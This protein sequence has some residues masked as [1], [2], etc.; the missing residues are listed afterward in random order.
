[1][2]TS[3]KKP[4]PVLIQAL[5]TSVYG[6]TPTQVGAELLLHADGSIS[7]NLG[8][9]HLEHAVRLAILE[10]RISLPWGSKR[11][12]L[13]GENDQCCGGVVEVSL[14]HIPRSLAPLY[15]SQGDRYYIR[16]GDFLHLLGGYTG[17]GV[18]FG[19]TY[20][21]KYQ[22]LVP[23]W[24]GKIFYVPAPPKQPLWIFGAG[25]VGRAI[26]LLSSTLP[27]NTMVFDNRSEWLDPRAFPSGVKL[28]ADWAI[29]RLPEAS[30]ATIV[31][32]LTYS[33]AL[34][35]QLLRYFSL[36]PLAYL[37]IIASK[38]KAARFRHGAAREGWT[39]HPNLHM[40]MGLPGMGKQP[41]EIAV[42]VFAEILQIRQNMKN[43]E[44][45]QNDRCQKTS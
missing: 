8:G 38:S 30:P 12:V 27:F 1:M 24:N 15:E 26:A 45:E 2:K 39:L 34:D 19:E 42:S 4:S 28:R 17:T 3:Q 6:S 10:G 25:H 32:V 22:Q 11:F 9:G 31:L 35:F 37:G 41:F 29:D 7:G 5:V 21:C 36:I 13:G 33:H 44:G 20:P 43:E 14:I 16:K 18:A 40:P 23:G